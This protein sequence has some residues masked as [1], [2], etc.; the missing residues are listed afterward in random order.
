MTVD[1]FRKSPA[2]PGGLTPALRAMWHDA[3][4]DW[5]SAH[6]IAQDDDSREAAWVHAYL[7]R[8]EGDDGN[9]GYWYRRAGRSAARGPLESEWQE[10][11]DALL[12]S[13]GM[14][15]Q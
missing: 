2:E 5:E 7:H 8:R 11:V 6:R 15:K 3:K 1:E 4:G 9:A 10:I 12:R 13:S 14:G